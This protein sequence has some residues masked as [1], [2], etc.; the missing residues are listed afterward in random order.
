[1]ARPKVEWTQREYGQ[2]EE[3]CN[4]QC[5][6]EEICAVMRVTD[7]TLNRLLKE[8]Y[9]QGFSETYKKY[10]AGGKASLRRI[11]FR[12]AEKNAAMA[13]WLGKQWLGQKESPD[14]TSLAALTKLDQIL[15]GI[16]KDVADE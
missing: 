14:E 15:A 5:T 13:I 8:E 16:Q 12:L 6:E 10:S 11:Q 4:I 9:G 1:M 2:F 7:K 3:L